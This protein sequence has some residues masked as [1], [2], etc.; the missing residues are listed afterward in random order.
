VRVKKKIWR[1]REIMPT[2]LG[3]LRT[4][5]MSRASNRLESTGGSSEPTLFVYNVFAAGEVAE[6]LKAAVC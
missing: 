3:G 1:E 6:R 2:I 4:I 5:R